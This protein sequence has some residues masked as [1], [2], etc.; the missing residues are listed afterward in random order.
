[1]KPK[2]S[3]LI[4]I[5]SLLLIMFFLTSTTTSGCK[6]D[7]ICVTPDL[8]QIRE[9]PQDTTE[10]ISQS[11]IHSLGRLQEKRQL[12]DSAHDDFAAIRVMLESMPMSTSEFRLGG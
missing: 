4:K 8:S 2:I 10:E 7:F 1:M 3:F 6:E 12:D 9:S 11:V 5:F